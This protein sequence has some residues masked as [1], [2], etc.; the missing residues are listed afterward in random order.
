[1]KNTILSFLALF[2][3]VLAANSQDL[4]ENQLIENTIYNFVDKADVVADADTSWK[5]GGILG[6]N[7]SQTYLNNWAAGGQSS[8][9]GTAYLNLF[10]N[11]AE[12][13]WA[14]DNNLQL[15]YGLLN[16]GIQEGKTVKIDDKIYINSIAGKKASE[17]WY[18]T[19]NL[20]F[21]SQFAPGYVIEDGASTNKK[22]SD[23][24]APGFLEGG[25][26][27]SYK[28]NDNFILT[29][30]PLA[31]KNTIVNSA[32]SE[33]R[34]NYGLGL[35]QGIRSEFG[36]SLKLNYRRAL[37]ENAEWQ[38]NLIMF[39]NYLE[40]PGNVDI[41]WENLFAV[42]VGK[43][44]NVN[45]IVQMIYDHDILIQKNVNDENGNPFLVEDPDNPGA[46]IN[47]QRGVSTLQLREVFGIGFSYKF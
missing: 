24:F 33:L 47:L 9:S 19:A 3:F 11:Y 37:A 36:G 40:N 23:L 14:W 31:T 5:K 43:Y 34:P 38:T 46:F 35:D 10:R 39:S 27:M 4:D 18:Y 28:P 44:F 32:N 29:I 25:L 12:G 2:T 7:T 26:G 6:F 42:K 22:I 30:S 21:L 15:S 17:F 20:S 8:I 45:F 41:N 1:M 13:D 16:N